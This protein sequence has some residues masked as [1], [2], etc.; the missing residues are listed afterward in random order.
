LALASEPNKSGT[1]PSCAL[2]RNEL[3]ST[4]TTIFCLLQELLEVYTR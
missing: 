1:V 4:R 3:D 2:T